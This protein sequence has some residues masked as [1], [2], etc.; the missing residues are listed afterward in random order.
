MISH[1]AQVIPSA[2]SPTGLLVDPF[3]RFWAIVNPTFHA[4][5]SNPMATIV[6]FTLGFLLFDGRWTDSLWHDDVTLASPAEASKIARDFGGVP[7]NFADVIRL[8]RGGQ[9]EHGCSLTWWPA[10]DLRAVVELEPQGWTGEERRR[11]PQGWTGEE[12]RRVRVE[13]DGEAVRR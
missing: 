1:L 13:L 2:L 4:T 3:E 8:R 7:A 9:P 5:M 11:E 12:R 10:A 6:G